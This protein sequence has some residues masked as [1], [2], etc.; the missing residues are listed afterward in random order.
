MFSFYFNRLF[1][2]RSE[3]NPGD[4]GVT[5]GESAAN[6]DEDHDGTSWWS[7]PTDTVPSE[8]G[9]HANK[10]VR[11]NIPG[12]GAG[13]SSTSPSKQP[14]HEGEQAPYY[15]NHS[16]LIYSRSPP[17]QLSL[18]NPDGGGRLEDAG[19]ASS[20]HYFG[21]LV[22]TAGAPPGGSKTP[23]GSL[24]TSRRHLLQQKLERLFDLVSCVQDYAS[25]PLASG[26]FAAGGHLQGMHVGASPVSPISPSSLVRS[27]GGANVNHHHAQ[28]FYYLRH[29]AAGGPARSGL[30]TGGDSAFLFPPPLDSPASSRGNEIHMLEN[31]DAQDHNLNLGHHH[32][33]N[34]SPNSL[35]TQQTLQSNSRSGVLLPD[36]AYPRRPTTD[37]SVA[38]TARF[39]TSLASVATMQGGAQ[40]QQLQ[41]P[42]STTSNARRYSR[43]RPTGATAVNLTHPA[44]ALS[45]VHKQQHKILGPKKGLAVHFGHENWNMVLN[46]MI[47]IRLAVGRS[48]TEGDRGLQSLDFKMRDKFAIL[49][50]LA[51]IMDSVAAANQ[52]YTIFV[53]YL[54]FVFRKIRQLRGIKPEQY[55]RSV[56]PEQLLGNMILGNLSSLSELS[57][58]GKSGAFFYYTADGS[59]MIKTISKEEKEWLQT[60][61]LPYWL[62]LKK[63]PDSLLIKFFGLHALRVRKQSNNIGSFRASS[64]IRE[65]KIYFVVMGNMFNTPYEIHTRYDL[66]GSTFGR[67]TNASLLE[68][69]TVARKDMDFLHEV[70]ASA[71]STAATRGSGGTAGTSS[72]ATAASSSTALALKRTGATPDG[73]ATSSS[74]APHNQRSKRNQNQPL[75]AAGQNEH[76]EEQHHDEPAVSTHVPVVLSQQAYQI[77]TDQLRADSEFLAKNS[78]IDYSL[79]LGVHTVAPEDRFDFWQAISDLDTHNQQICSQQLMLNNTSRPHSPAAQYLTNS[80][81]QQPRTPTLQLTANGVTEM[82]TSLLAATSSGQAGGGPAPFTSGPQQARGFSNGT[83]TNSMQR[84]SFPLRNHTAAAQLP[85]SIAYHEQHFGGLAGADRENPKL[86][87]IGVIDILTHYGVRKN[88]EH[89]VKSCLHP[90]NWKGVSCCPPDMYAERFLKFMKDIVFRPTNYTGDVGALAEENQSGADKFSPTAVFH[91]EIVP[92]SS[93][94][95]TTRQGGGTLGPPPAASGASGSE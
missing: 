70:T 25:S 28:Q 1:S 64:K 75:S 26:S 68:D 82:S 83:T 59:F 87:Y 86:Y 31:H 45:R 15:K 67:T 78:I 19:A 54:P 34:E 4:K 14:T 66:K 39:G 81:Y 74:S 48:S 55:L 33:N 37:V 20:S 89:R 35:I 62:H 46:M 50:N 17:P 79:L 58:E 95:G 11:P 41:L 57:S 10:N 12:G 3:A 21:S 65:K 69:K 44:A 38:T 93:S 90:T 8:P 24:F 13:N 49:P 40:H 43:L 18:P 29:G 51:N 30:Q 7:P 88:I 9:Q 2:R 52:N 23:A 16:N 42:G 63:Y 56:G 71:T 80:N 32:E 77:I 94:S 72:S 22:K 36:P 53:D 27:P 5:G 84:K 92:V 73:G 61:M 60:I 76:S 85:P 91:H 6:S 47:G